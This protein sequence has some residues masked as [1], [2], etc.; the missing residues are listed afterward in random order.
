MQL[1]SGKTKVTTTAVHLHSRLCSVR[2]FM[3]E[4]AQAC[5]KHSAYHHNVCSSISGQLQSAR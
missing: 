3:Q 4:L 2:I 1:A 5:D